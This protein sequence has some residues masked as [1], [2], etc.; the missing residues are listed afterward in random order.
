[1]WFAARLGQ[2]CAAPAVP[3]RDATPW[4][5]PAA[6]AGVRRWR[7]QKFWNCY[8]P[9]PRRRQG[10]APSAAGLNLFERPQLAPGHPPACQYLRQAPRLTRHQTGRPRRLLLDGMLARR[11]MRRRRC[12]SH[13]S[14]AV[15]AT[16]AWRRTDAAVHARRL[17]LG[18]VA[19]MGRAGSSD[20]LRGASTPAG[21][22]DSCSAIHI[23]TRLR[24]SLA[25]FIRQDERRWLVAWVVP[26]H[27]G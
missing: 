11:H 27:P 10:Q 17:P 13:L 25:V 26:S 20:L 15:P 12:D 2:N 3:A 8:E 23:T 1:M 16:N 21:R 4:P 6:V 24:R 5:V 19:P 9:R 18:G 7:P 22:Q 14:L